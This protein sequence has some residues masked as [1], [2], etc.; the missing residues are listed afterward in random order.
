MTSLEQTPESPWRKRTIEGLNLDIKE[1]IEAKRPR[2]CYYRLE[3]ESS[4]ATDDDTESIASVQAKETDFVGDTSDTE[5]KNGTGTENSEFEY[6]VASLS[7]SDKDNFDFSTTDSEVTEDMIL[8]AAAAA[9][10]DS[11][12][13]AWITD[14]EDSDSSSEEMSFGKTDFATCVQCKGENRNPLY[15]YCEK[16]FQD[17]KK[18]FPPR[19][20][21]NRRKKQQDPVKLAT[22]RN[23]LSGL[24][25]D[26]GIGSSQECPPLGLDQIVVPEFLNNA[27]TSKSADLPSTLTKL[28]NTKSSTKSELLTN[29]VKESASTSMSSNAKGSTLRRKRQSSESSLSDYEVKKTK[30]TP[31][32]DNITSDLGS[33]VSS[34]TSSFTSTISTLSVDQNGIQ[35][36]KSSEKN[37]SFVSDIGFNS[38]KS[39]GSIDLEKTNSFSS[40]KT[41]SDLCMFCNSAPKDSIFLHAKIA[42]RCCCY[43]CAKKTLKSI[44]RCPICNTS[45]NKVVRI[46]TC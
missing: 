42:H 26:S 38:N 32:P 10:C 16:C 18:F 19:P 5:S 27:G 33:E 21:R 41:E 13:E 20:R 2:L 1:I 23:C 15:R 40:D 25:Q 6:E 14:V 37:N 12:L 22:L 17:R 39:G 7:A 29:I 43:A 9:I 44:K 34:S 8:V 31:K 4:K 24:S 46:F 30:L 36:E 45:V 11:S 28:N 35:S 3:S